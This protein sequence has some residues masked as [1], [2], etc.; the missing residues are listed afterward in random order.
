LKLAI[1]KEKLTFSVTEK[2]DIN[3]KQPK[4]KSDSLKL[5]FSCGHSAQ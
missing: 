5:N 3:E 1:E 4:P 2:D